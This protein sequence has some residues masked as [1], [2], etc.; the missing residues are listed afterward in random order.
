MRVSSVKGAILIT[1]SQDFA[2]RL[3][4]M[5]TG[6]TQALDANATA[7]P[8]KP[9]AVF[10]KTPALEEL[11]SRMLVV[12]LAQRAGIANDGSLSVRAE[13]TNGKKTFVLTQKKDG[14]EKEWRFE[15]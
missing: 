15:E 14:A 5:E 9:L 10:T 6:S 11:P 8:R 4:Y 12:Y 1:D 13:E 3:A 7:L 2:K